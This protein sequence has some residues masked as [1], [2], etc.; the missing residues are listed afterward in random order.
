MRFLPKLTST[1]RIIS[2]PGRRDSYP[3]FP[4]SWPGLITSFQGDAV[5][6]VTLAR[7]LR[8][9]SRY[10]GSL[11]SSTS[12]ADRPL[13]GAVASF[14]QVPGRGGALSRLRQSALRL[15]F[16]RQHLKHFAKICSQFVKH[17]ALGMRDKYFV[18]SCD[19][20]TCVIVPVF[21]SNY[22]GEV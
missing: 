17:C 9:F 20:R 7:F 22:R 12:G 2:F 1:G 16:I 10:G 11:S 5:L 19:G 14:R 18:F 4:F 8:P 6:S 3:A 13:P 15:A 21:P